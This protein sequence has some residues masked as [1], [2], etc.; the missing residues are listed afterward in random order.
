MDVVCICNSPLQH[1][2]KSY[3]EGEGRSQIYVSCLC[4]YSTKNQYRERTN[5]M[6]SRF[7]FFALFSASPLPFLV[8][9]IP[10]LSS[11]LTLLLIFLMSYHDWLSGFSLW[12]LIGLFQFYFLA[13]SQTFKTD[14]RSKG[15]GEKDDDK[16]EKKHSKKHENAPSFHLKPY[17][18]SVNL[19]YIFR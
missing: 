19:S 9:H 4:N 2:T 11:P 13:L 12:H 8:I 18:Y 15:K 7:F 1:V 10:F 14:S 5:G 17:L 3:K 16:G 6:L